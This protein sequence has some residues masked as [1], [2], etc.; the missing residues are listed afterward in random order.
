MV[1]HSRCRRNRRHKPIAQLVHFK[2]SEILEQ[3]K[4]NNTDCDSENGSELKGMEMLEMYY[5]RR[6]EEN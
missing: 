1:F 4:Y 5:I 2:E 3:K 6:W